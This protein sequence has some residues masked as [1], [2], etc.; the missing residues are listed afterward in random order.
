[1]GMSTVYTKGKKSQ[2]QDRDRGNSPPSPTFGRKKAKAHHEDF[3]NQKLQNHSPYRFGVS[4]GLESPEPN[5]GGSVI[6]NRL[7][8]KIHAPEDFLIEPGEPLHSP[9]GSQQNELSPTPSITNSKRQL[10]PRPGNIVRIRGRTSWGRKL[11][12]NV[13]QI[14]G[15][16]FKI[17]EEEPPKA[18]ESFSHA[19]LDEEFKLCFVPKERNPVIERATL[20]DQKISLLNSRMTNMAQ[21]IQGGLKKLGIFPTASGMVPVSDFQRLGKQLNMAPKYLDQL[22]YG[23]AGVCDENGNVDL[24]ALGILKTS[25]ASPVRK[26]G[27]P[28]VEQAQYHRS[29]N[30]FNSPIYMSA[31]LNVGAETKKS[32][33]KKSSSLPALSQHNTIDQKG[34]RAKNPP[35]KRGLASARWGDEHYRSTFSLTQGRQGSALYEKN[36]FERKK[37]LFSE[38]DHQT[39]KKFKQHRHALYNDHENKLQNRRAQEHWL[40]KHLE[41]RKSNTIMRQAA[42]Y[43]D[44][45]SKERIRR[46]TLWSDSGK[47]YQDGLPQRLEHRKHQYKQTIDDGS[48]ATAMGRRNGLQKREWERVFKRSPVR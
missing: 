14:K 4:S 11:E 42:R 9:S 25:V 48:Y 28:S 20:E 30:G 5:A 23:K 33:M 46:A 18:H 26:R 8:E 47:H 6:L 43:E 35:W 34:V 12:K 17:I 21:N 15:T 2:A 32:L 39:K 31:Q 38:I 24:V 16:T 40:Q 44:F 19:S 36:N 10:G 22:V 41:T 1:M 37:V 29:R 45:L 13:A 27:G 7:A 3:V